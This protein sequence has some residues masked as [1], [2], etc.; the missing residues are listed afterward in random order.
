[1]KIEQIAI[2]KLVPNERNPRINDKAVDAVARSIK[3]Y[4][5]NNPIITD[6]DLNIAAGHTRLKAAM[7]LGLKQVPVIRIPGLTGSK[8]TGFSIADNKTADIADWNEELL[9]ELVWELNEDAD[10]D[11]SSLGFDDTELTSILDDFR[12]DGS[13]GDSKSL[14]DQFGVPPFSVL[15]ARQGYWQDRKASWIALGIESEVGRKRNLAK[16]SDL[17]STPTGA[18]SGTSIFDPVLCELAYRWF[19][20]SSGK[21][22]DPFAGGSVRGVVAAM[23][24]MEYTGVDLSNVQVQANE[25]NWKEIKSSHATKIDP[26][27]IV[28]DSVNI[29]ALTS[30][31]FDLIFS[32][33]PYGDLEEYSDDARD[34]SKMSH[35]DFLEAYKTI[36]K[37]SCSML[38]QNRFACFIV[39][40]FR[41]KAGFCRNFV[42]D[43]IEAFQE[44]G[45]HLYND[46][47]LVTAIGTLPMRV[48]KYFRSGRKLGRTHQNVLVFWKGDKVKD[49]PPLADNDFKIEEDSQE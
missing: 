19:G 38:K 47:I 11:I 36:I 7:Q 10:F 17:V 31:E 45:L 13:K 35:D 32:C 15:D 14:A 23:L 24:D 3:A 8:F 30:D 27:W 20:R 43:T 34:L 18:L 21:I 1:M 16:Y 48:G 42:S 41:D 33:P 26:K 12:S 25:K 28:G 49:L 40:D 22:L 9:G 37:E 2:D 44:C 5:F 29:K 6:G 39:S 46:A 4:G